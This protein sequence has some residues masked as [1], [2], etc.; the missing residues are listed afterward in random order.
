MPDGRPDGFAEHFLMPPSWAALEELRIAASPRPREPL[1]LPVW[2]NPDH[3][4][5]LLALPFDLAWA[6]T[7][8]AEANDWIAPLVGLP[9]LPFIAWQRPRPVPRG[10]GCWKTPEIVAWA[11]GRP[12][13]WVDDEI[14]RADQD[15]VRRNHP[16]P[17]L[18]LP[19]DASTGLTAADLAT[20]SAW[21]ESLT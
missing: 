5:R 19:V 4:A 12:F 13:A 14:A 1:P 3:G 9:E 20:L 18:L 16:A 7:W 8:E 6:T 21:A 11:A 10:R 17:A 15:W 2:L